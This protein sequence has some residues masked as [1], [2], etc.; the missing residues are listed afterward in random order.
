MLPAQ[1]ADRQGTRIAH[2]LAC[3]VVAVCGSLAYVRQQVHLD[4][5]PGTRPEVPSTP[6]ME[7]TQFGV[8]SP[9]ITISRDSPLANYGSHQ[10]NEADAKRPRGVS[11]DVSNMA[12]G[13]L[14]AALGALILFAMLRMGEA[15]LVRRQWM[16][17]PGGLL[18]ASLVGLCIA[19]AMPFQHTPSTQFTTAYLP[20][21]LAAGL[22]CWS[23]PRIGL[24]AGYVVLGVS[25][26]MIAEIGNATISASVPDG[27]AS[28]LWLLWAM[29]IVAEALIASPLVLIRRWLIGPLASDSPIPSA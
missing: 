11:I 14:L 20:M 26:T 13:L 28:S 23:R 6:F 7:R 9:W 2:L 5:G 4:S 15:W 25:V 21:S 19:C 17:S 16:P 29:W 1:P 3:F 8:P 22:C 27:Y 24:A 12:V 10:S 18:V